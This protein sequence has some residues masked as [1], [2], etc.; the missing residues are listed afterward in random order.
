MAFGEGRSPS[1][2]AAY[3]A[4]VVLAVAGCA[5]ETETA[6]PTS[7]PPAAS[8]APA[9]TASVTTSNVPTT[10]AEQPCIDSGTHE[11]IQHALTGPGAEAVLCPYAVFRLAKTIEMTAASQAIYTRG[12][13]TD[14]SRA[15]LRVEGPEVYVAVRAGNHDDVALRNVIID[16][17]EDL[18]RGPYG[19][20][21]EWGGAASG[22]V[23]EWVKAFKPR[24]WSVLY[25]GE[26]DDRKCRQAVARHNELGPAGHHVFGMADGISLACPDSVVEH[27]TIID[28]T[29]G[30]IVIF[31]AP[32]SVVA[33]NTIISRTRTSFYGISMED[34]GP[35]DGDYTGTRVLDNVIEAEG[36]L[37]RRGIS[38]G[39]RVG[40]IPPDET[41]PVNRGAVVTG[42]TLRGTHMGYGFVVAGVTDWTVKGNMDDSTHRVPPYPVDCFGNAVDAPAG[43]QMSADSAEGSFQP[44]FVSATLGFSV[45]WWPNQVVSD[46]ACLEE[47]LGEDALEAIRSGGAGPIQDALRNASEPEPLYTCQNVYEPPVLEPGM[48]NV[49]I[50]VSACEPYCATVELFNSS[51]VPVDLTRVEFILEDFIVDCAGLPDTLRPQEM[52]MCTVDNW[53]ADGFQVL[54]FAGLPPQW[55]GWGFNYPFAR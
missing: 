14:D 30:G 34:Y 12:F 49:A 13:P 51:D 15:L 16:G 8:H 54:W 19:A 37:I 7:P 55:T 21:I 18:G 5:P 36:A 47:M 39:T 25:L 20:L 6:D 22:H 32:G 28:A 1:P 42:N 24:G 38:M 27:N 53:V 17:N 10:A 52:A 46:E 9:P 44:E 11:S 23:V 2:L 29:D 50:L 41:G 48:G 35:W 4:V 26:G 45:E 43:F 31:Q 3:L 40:C 33:N